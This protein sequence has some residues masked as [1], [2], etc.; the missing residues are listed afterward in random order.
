MK[1]KICG[2]P[3]I[4]L[5]ALTNE[6]WQFIKSSMQLSKESQVYENFSH[7]TKNDDVPNAENVETGQKFWHSKSPSREQLTKTLDWSLKTWE[8]PLP[9][10]FPH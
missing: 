8:N 6:K 2:F 3:E 1:I 7:R 4:I 5:A 10:F 9:S